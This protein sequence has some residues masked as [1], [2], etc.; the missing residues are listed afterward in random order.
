M[1]LRFT[2]LTTFLY[3]IPVFV[4]G[5]PSE[6]LNNP[7]SLDSIDA[8][9]IALVRMVQ[10]ISTPIVLFFFIYGGFLFV[11]ARGN[12]ESLDRAKKALIYAIIGGVVIAGAEVL[13]DII[14][15]TAD[16]F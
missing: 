12:A 3:L 4:Y 9:L 2:S 11:T 7:L 16:A 5:G 14:G 1:K 13:V 10:I 8:L 6:R 15:N